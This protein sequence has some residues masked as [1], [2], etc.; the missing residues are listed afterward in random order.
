MGIFNFHSALMRPIQ[1]SVDWQMPRLRRA[2]GFFCCSCRLLRMA[3]CSA[4]SSSTC[5]Q[6]PATRGWL[7]LRKYA[8]F[9]RCLCW[10]HQTAASAMRR[11]SAVTPPMA[12]TLSASTQSPQMA[13]TLYCLEA[14]PAL[15]SATCAP[16]CRF[17]L[18]SMPPQH[19][20][21]TQAISTRA[22]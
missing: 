8:Y 22:S 16:T 11:H 9:L 1:V 15:A 19:T 13:K 3:P 7:I 20:A 4:L 10:K 21:Q 6:W 2:R 14:S 12:Q 18:G 17:S 5:L